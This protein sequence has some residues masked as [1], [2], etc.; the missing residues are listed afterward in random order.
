MCEKIVNT[1][2]M[3]AYNIYNPED[4]FVFLF[5]HLLESKGL[6]S[7]I[8][9]NHYELR[10]DR[11]IRVDKS[12]FGVLRSIYQ[13]A[14]KDQQKYYD[15]AIEEFREEVRNCVYEFSLLQELFIQPIKAKLN[16]NFV[17]VDM[18]LLKEL[19]VMMKKEEFGIVKRELEEL[20]EKELV[21]EQE[22]QVMES[23]QFNF[24]C[25]VKKP[26]KSAAEVA[27]FGSEHC[28]RCWKPRHAICLLCR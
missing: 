25:S 8:L 27:S 7:M 24:G 12:V 15:E 2:M 10:R 16:S 5:K 23:E 13:R 14:S 19:Q 3:I 28:Y 1:S 22:G 21:L 6:N 17:E 11:K 18:G 4:N 9:S 20:L 26:P